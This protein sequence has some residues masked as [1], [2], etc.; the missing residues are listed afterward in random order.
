[1][2][3]QKLNFNF[4][5]RGMRNQSHLLLEKSISNVEAL[6]D[7]IINPLDRKHPNAAYHEINPDELRSLVNDYLE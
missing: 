7:K 3:R 2:K 5:K 4:H 1:M 6:G